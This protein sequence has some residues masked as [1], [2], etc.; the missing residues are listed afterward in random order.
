MR[1]TRE[2]VAA[3]IPGVYARL[4]LCSRPRPRTGAGIMSGAVEGVALLPDDEMV[5]QAL[6]FLFWAA[7]EG[8]SPINKDDGPDPEDVFWQYSLRTGDEDWETLAER[9]R[10]SRTTPP[11]RSYADGVE[12]S[13]KVA[14]KR[15]EFETSGLP[16]RCFD[17]Q[18]LAQRNGGQIIA[19]AIRLLSQGEK[20]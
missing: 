18:V 17:I 7:G 10:A 2:P 9:Y 6:R 20:A 3:G 1:S 19:A 11:A 8:F 15:F 13:A 14:E 5:Y 12:D 16:D 4:E